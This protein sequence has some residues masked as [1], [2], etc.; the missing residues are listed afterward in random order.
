MEQRKLLTD[1]FSWYTN[2][3]FWKWVGGFTALIVLFYIAVLAVGF[4]MP[5][6]FDNPMM[7]QVQASGA[8][9]AFVFLYFASLL[10]IIAGAIL[11]YVNIITIALKQHGLPA[12]PITIVSV[13]KFAVLSI[14][15]MIAVCIL[16]GAIF[17]GFMAFMMLMSAISSSKLLTIFGVMLYALPALAV[18][19]YVGARLSIINVYFWTK[20]NCGILE[21]ISL[22]L[23]TTNGRVREI[24]FA[25]ILLAVAFLV[26]LLSFYIYIIIA[27]VLGVM[28]SLALASISAYLLI[29]PAILAVLF[30][31]AM[32]LAQEAITFGVQTYW[33][34]GLY[35]Q[36]VKSPQKPNPQKSQAKKQ[37]KK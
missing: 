15:V 31:L 7:D 12:N 34:V 5:S 20:Q 29:I 30:Y 18:L 32:L 2:R 19:L 22:S 28:L 4:S 25:Q 21:A 26:V 17:L 10:V 11:V 1:A 8:A 14:A 24:V 23:K 3:E 27:V 16:L 6:L 36:L 37:R 9:S 13:L 35:K 33:F